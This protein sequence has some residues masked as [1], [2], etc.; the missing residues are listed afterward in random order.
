MQIKIKKLEKEIA[1]FMKKLSEEE[2]FKKRE[3]TLDEFHVW[4]AIKIRDG[5]IELTDDPYKNEELLENLGK[6]FGFQPFQINGQYI[7]RM[8]GKGAL[9]PTPEMLAKIKATL[10]SNT[11]SGKD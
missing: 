11:T 4:L 5:E 9:P 6:M 3:Q 10:Q 2:W 1:E 7:I 8:A